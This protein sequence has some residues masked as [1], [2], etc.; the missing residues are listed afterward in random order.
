MSVDGVDDG[1]MPRD[2]AVRSEGFRHPPHFGWRVGAREEM[3]LPVGM[4]AGIAEDS[5]D[6]LAAG[7]ALAVE[8][9]AD[10]KGPGR[11]G[12]FHD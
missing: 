11:S 10:I 8:I 1:R 4:P 7:L 2:Q 5:G 6:L 9:R 3:N 12:R